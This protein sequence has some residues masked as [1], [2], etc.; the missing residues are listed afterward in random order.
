MPQPLSRVVPSATF[1]I[2][3][4]GLATL[5]RRPK[6]AIAA[7][8]CIASWSHVERFLL[9][10]YV[11][12]AGGEEA[13]AAAVYLAMETS[14]AKSEAIRVLSE[15]KLS[16]DHR[17][18]MQAIIRVSKACQKERDKLAHWSWGT[19]PELPEALLLAD[20]R[21]LNANPN[22]IYVYRANDFES[23]RHRFD[24]IAS[25]GM[26]LKFILMDHVANHEGRLYA[27]LCAEPEI[28]SI[29]SRQAAPKTLP[30]QEWP[31]WLQPNQD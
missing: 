14:T 18:L 11:Q 28:A 13:D 4:V 24:R 22:N 27:K 5:R 8:E 10:T 25:W 7:M 1:E 15:R 16:P 26:L 3:N 6:L 29:L 30:P 20:P 23:M 19:S 2:G 31:E 17:A 12:L 9:G 21:I